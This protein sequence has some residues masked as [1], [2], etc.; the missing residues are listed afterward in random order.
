[1]QQ[2]TVPQFIDVEDKILGPVTIRQFIIMLVG[3]II[4]FL[5]YRFGDLGTFIL[6]LAV[7]GSLSLLFAFVKVNGQTFHYF[8][9]NII[10]TTRKPS[11]RIWHKSYESKELNMLRKLDSDIEVVQA[12]VKKAV[13]RQHIRDLSLVVNTG[14]YYKADE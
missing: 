1:M 2:F 8:L 13:K 10:Q 11:L 12:V 14:G 3:C 6:V 9:L 4:I 7:V 5:G